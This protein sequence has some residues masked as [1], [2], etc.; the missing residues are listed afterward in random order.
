MLLNTIKSSLVHV[1]IFV[2]FVVI[3]PETLAQ[4]RLSLSVDAAPV[5]EGLRYNA[6]LT[7]VE[8]R[9]FGGIR[10]GTSLH[11]RLTP[12]WSLSSGLWLEWKRAINR[13]KC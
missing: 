11:F 6:T 2:L 13:D 3:S 10:A 4:S 8:P 7:E 1:G 9:N 5:Y 12:H